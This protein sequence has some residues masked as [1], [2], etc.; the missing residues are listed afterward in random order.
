MTDADGRWRFDLLEPGAYRVELELPG[1]D[2][3][4]YTWTTPRSAAAPRADAD[5]DAEET[6]PGVARTPVITVGAGTAGVRPAT[7]ADGLTAA[8][9]DDTWDAGLVERPVAVGDLVWF[10]ADLDGLQGP[11]EEGVPGVVVELRTTDGRAVT[12]ASGAPVGPVTTDAD[13]AYAFTGLLPGEYVVR[14][15]RIAS[16]AAL[17]GYAPTV[18]G[19]GSDPALDSATWTATSRV[20]VGGESDPTLDFG[21]VL[22]DD[23]QL[24]LRKVPVA[25]TADSVTW[26]V[27]VMSTG[28][29][30]AYAGFTVV[31]AL[32]G[33]LTFRSASGTGFD[34]VAVDRVVTC[35]HDGPLPAGSPP[36]C[37]SS[38]ASPR[39]GRRSPTRRPC[40]ST[41]GATGST[42]SR[43][44][45]WRGASRP[46]ARA[47]RPARHRAAT[48]RPRAPTR[49]GRWWRRAC[50]SR[51][52]RPCWRSRRGG[53][54]AGC[55]RRGAGTGPDGP[56]GGA[57]GA[58]E[59]P[60]RHGR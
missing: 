2:A 10:D 55:A 30:D 36:P 12:D 9:V 3:A 52:A 24:A 34:C 18:A 38:R 8:Y 57:R 5:S 15:D 21:L 33:S 4:R 20:L 16:A 48:S 56:P 41:A 1:P 43:P 27:T 46:G 35:D 39:P 31:D 47:A 53:P 44:T 13:G 19:A 25:R 50:C 11:D 42:C 58:G 37:G 22:A 45:T 29:Q 59:E 28:T 14:L 17:A 54:G 23:V 7:A 49:P 60:A 6:A 40:R 51:S 32:P 26:D